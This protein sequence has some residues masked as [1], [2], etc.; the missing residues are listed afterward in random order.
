MHAC[1]NNQ[2]FCNLY[3]FFFFFKRKD[4]K[5]IVWRLQTVVKNGKHIEETRCKPSGLSILKTLMLSKNIQGNYTKLWD[6]S[7][8]STYCCYLM[9]SSNRIQVSA[10]IS[11]QRPCSANSDFWDAFLQAL[12]RTALHEMYVPFSLPKIQYEL[13]SLFSVCCS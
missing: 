13:A 6:S 9:H 2:D 1:L 10:E 8:F 11:T 5:E 3:C 4:Q 12:W 7:C